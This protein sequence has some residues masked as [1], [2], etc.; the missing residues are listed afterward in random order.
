MAFIN[1]TKS[2][3]RD[4]ITGSLWQL[5]ITNPQKKSKNKLTV[6]TFHRVLP[7]T[8]RKQYPYEGICVTPEELDWF[9]DYFKQYDVVG[10]L[11]DTFDQWK[12][13]TDS[14]KSFLAITFDD[15]QWDN[16][17]YAQPILDKHNYKATFYIPTESVDNKTLLWH[18]RLGYVVHQAGNDNKQLTDIIN[19]FKALG[20][21]ES[22]AT[23]LKNKL[24]EFAKILSVGTR[25]KLLLQLEQLSAAEVPQWGRLMTW[26]EIKLLDKQGHEIG[27]HSVTHELLTSCDSSQLKHEV[28]FSKERIEAELSKKVVSF[29]YP[30]GNYNDEVVSAVTLAGFDNAVSTVWGI[31]NQSANHYTM[32]RFDI[33]AFNNLDRHQNLSASRFAYRLMKQSLN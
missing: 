14:A 11:S 28:F 30:N 24:V 8:L 21:Q 20:Y 1:T 32:R 18:D 17:H 15:A 7:E 13:N 33:N 9:C 26:D 5:G 29:C 23:D 31:N 16:L 6:V 22:Q 27:A 2:F 4:L 10:T 25:K 19:I 3:I 12:K